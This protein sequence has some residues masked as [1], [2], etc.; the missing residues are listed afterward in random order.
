MRKQPSKKKVVEPLDPVELV[1]K[2][3]QTVGDTV[4]EIV[5]DPEPQN[6]LPPADLVPETP[7]PR[8]ARAKPAS[9]PAAGA[10]GKRAAANGGR[11]RAEKLPVEQRRRI[12]K[13]AAAAKLR[14]DGGK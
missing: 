12:A 3:V 9:K 5:A 8:A 14:Q 1:T 10:R 4:K 6:R 7:P 2:V 11:S 13:K